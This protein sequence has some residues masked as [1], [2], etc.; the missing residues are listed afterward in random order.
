MTVN[1]RGDKLPGFV[2]CVLWLAMISGC[3][4]PVPGGR[5][6]PMPAVAGVVEAALIATHAGTPT[7]SASRASIPQGTSTPFPSLIPSRTRTT[8][9]TPTLTSTRRPSPTLPFT[10][11]PTASPLPGDVTL[12]GYSVEGRPIEVYRFGDG[13]IERMI[14]A[15]MH[16]GY[17]WNTIALAGQLIVHLTEHPELVPPDVTLFILR[18]LNP[19]GEA[20]SRGVSGRVNANGVDLNRNWPTLWQSDWP[21]DGCWRYAPTSAGS[22]PASEP[23][24][25]ALTGFLLTHRVD[26]LVNYHSAAQGIFPGGQPPD[27]ASLD[28]AAALAAVSDYPYP[29]LDFGCQFTGQLID[30]ASAHSLAALDVELTNHRDTDFDQNL[31]ILSVL[32]N[33]QR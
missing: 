4:A 31:A 8:T 25:V 16:G 7:G 13:P 19:D 9:P 2:A 32:L 28:L 14:V 21:R 5:D 30:W 17:E 24:T 11:T 3:A 23:E 29:P 20:R 26:A 6:R 1:P 10:Q 12:I 27:P 18:S 33:W 22:G 15:G